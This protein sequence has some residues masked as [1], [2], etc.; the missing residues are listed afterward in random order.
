[1][2]STKTDILALLKRNDG[3]TVDD[4][5]SS[6]GLASM[7]VRQ[8]L[9]KLERDALVHAEEVRRATGRP[10]FL[11]RLTEAGHRRVSEGYDRLVALLVEEAGR[12]EVNGARSEAERRI[13]L[14]RGAA[15]TLAAR[16]RAQVL[17]LEP[18]AQAERIAEVLR[19]VGGFPEWREHER[20]IDMRDFSCAMRAHVE[21]EGACPW[22][23]TL[24]SALVGAPVES[25]PRPDDG[26]AVCCRY[27]VPIR[28]TAPGWN[29]GSR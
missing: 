25:A 23:E 13:V 16:H 27:I 18:A 4:L 2:H 10:H 8:H 5:S 20:G 14:F 22:H 26:C 11:Y 15:A 24:L 1:M 9:T 3:A 17:G 12:M 21:I 29:R 6:L 19:S 7:T 28:A